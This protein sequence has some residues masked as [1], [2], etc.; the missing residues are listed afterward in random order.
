MIKK[1]LQ[2]EP[3]VTKTLGMLVVAVGARLG[4]QLTE[5]QVLVVVITLGSVLDLV[6]RQ[7]VTPTAKLPPVVE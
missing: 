4:L 3:V 5:A 6:V 1:F 2:T 7:L